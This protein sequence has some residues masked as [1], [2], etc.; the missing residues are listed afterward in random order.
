MTQWTRVVS[1]YLILKGNNYIHWSYWHVMIPPA[2][3]QMDIPF[4]LISHSNTLW[5]FSGMNTADQY[6]C[7]IWNEN[8]LNATQVTA[9]N[10][11]KSNWI[12]A[13]FGHFFLARKRQNRAHGYLRMPARV[14]S[15]SC[16]VWRPVQFPERRWRGVPSCGVTICTGDWQMDWRGPNTNP[17]S[18]HIRTRW[19]RLTLLVSSSPNA[20]PGGR[21]FAKPL[22]FPKEQLNAARKPRKVRKW[23]SPLSRP[24]PPR[25]LLRSL[26]RSSLTPA[27]DVNK[28]AASARSAAAPPPPLRSPASLA[29]EGRAVR[30]QRGEQYS[31]QGQRIGVG[32]QYSIGKKITYLADADIVSKQSRWERTT[33]AAGM[34]GHL[35]IC[36]GH[37]WDR[38]QLIPLLLSVYS[39]YLLKC[40]GLFFIGFL[41]FF[42]VVG[43]NDWLFN[44][45]ICINLVNCDERLD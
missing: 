18:S 41:A 44:N 1:L 43:L 15:S 7:I 33:S 23:A 19:L 11:T 22:V 2:A 36:F 6:L 14:S 37:S 10:K 30:R 40:W 29:M 17:H 31:G 38:T 24:P 34:Y 35:F 16:W 12:G 39:I 45:Y 4:T 27:P 25:F 21:G 32:G 13:R 5:L 28:H 3:N 42:R 26:A 8:A 9:S 20:S